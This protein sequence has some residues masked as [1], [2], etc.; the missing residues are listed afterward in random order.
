MAVPSA[1][2]AQLNVLSR[3][4]SVEEAAALVPLRDAE[5]VKNPSEPSRAAPAPNPTPP[6]RCLPSHLTP[7]M[8]ATEKVQLERT[9]CEKKGVWR[10][11]GDHEGGLERKG[12]LKKSGA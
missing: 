7:L 2:E 3:R 11:A 9:S 1:G 10:G 12:R 8:E 5:G 4:K 6:H